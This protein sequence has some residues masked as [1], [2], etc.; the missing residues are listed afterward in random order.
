MDMGSPNTLEDFIDF[1][2]IYYKYSLQNDCIIYLS[3]WCVCCCFDSIQIIK[4]TIHFGRKLM[5]FYCQREKH[6]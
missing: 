6:F 5:I 1:L 4:F 2:V 3:P